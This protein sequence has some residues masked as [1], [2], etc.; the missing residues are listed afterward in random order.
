MATRT[1][2][3]SMRTRMHART[4]GALATIVVALVTTASA[5][6]ASSVDPSSV[7]VTLA[8]GGST[9][10][11]KTVHTPEIPPNPDILFL[12]DTTG[13]M[14]GAIANVRTNANAIMTQV[15][16]AQPTTQFGAAEYKDEGDVFVYRLNQAITA[17]TADVTTGINQW[18][19][20]G[21]GDIPEGQLNALFMLS[22]SRAVGFRTGSSRIV[23]WFGAAPGHDPS[24]GH[25]LADAIGA[26]HA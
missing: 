14:S 25:T 17:T 4:A 11:P 8:P 7:S 20:G 19:A 12:A 22:T 5:L 23:V 1:R 18:V 26:Q 9:T 10:I 3:E 2:E 13:S 15:L 24:N 6:A 21:G 16:A